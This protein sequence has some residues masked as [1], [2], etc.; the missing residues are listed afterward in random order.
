[1]LSGENLKAFP[2]NQE[3]ENLATTLAQNSAWN[4]RTIMQDREK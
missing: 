4:L 3:W 1:M 2:L